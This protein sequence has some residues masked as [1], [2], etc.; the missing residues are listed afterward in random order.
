MAG[1]KA[2]VVGTGMMGPG[3]A[4]SL[5]ATGIETVL[6]GRTQESTQRGFS[7][8]LNYLQVLR[9]HQL[10]NAVQFDAGQSHLS[11]SSRLNEALST[12]DF[13]FE[14]IPENLALKQEFFKHLDEYSPKN[15]ILCSNT[16]GISITRIAEGAKYP[17]RIMT[18]HFWNPPHLMPLVEVVMGEKTDEGS[19]LRVMEIV[20]RCGKS[21][22]LVRKDT[23]GQLGNR[24]LQALVR[25]AI[26]IVQSGI[27][28]VEAVD[29]VVKRGFGLRMPVWGIL[30]HADAVGLDLVEAVQNYVLPHLNQ[31]TQA[32]PLLGEKLN[33]GEAGV[34][35]GKGFYDWEV[36]DIQ[37]AKRN[38]DEFLIEFLKKHQ[39]ERLAP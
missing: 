12:S 16:S 24:L 2:V 27:A 6:V 31:E 13:V 9:E 37:A 4:I 28:S 29:L 5:S 15:A 18:A 20:R 7:Q 34:K 30:E 33:L 1:L 14:S 23:P 17:E 35:S 25:E 21:P 36:R 8:S 10:I 32:S 38:R 26:H 39:S 3:I 11:S 22:V 19:A